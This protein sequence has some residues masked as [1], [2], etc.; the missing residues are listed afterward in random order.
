MTVDE[1]WLVLSQVVAQFNA[2]QEVWAKVNEAQTTIA[3]ALFPTPP[4]VA[5][6]DR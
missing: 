3:A 5:E 1:A 2:N 4:A 6:P